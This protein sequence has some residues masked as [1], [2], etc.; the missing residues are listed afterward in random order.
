MVRRAQAPSVSVVVPAKNEARNIAW[1]LQRIPS[2][3]DEVIVVDGLSSDGTL[4]IAKMIAP[5][6]IVIHEMRRGKGAA[7]LA[8]F[9]A[10][11]GD[12][13]VVLDADGSM[14]P[15][16]IDGFVGGLDA[17]F[18]LVKGSRFMRGG[19]STDISRLRLAGN[20]ALAALSNALYGTRFTELCYGFMALRRTM[21][22]RLGLDAT[23]FEIEAQIVSRAVRAGARI[24]EVPSWESPRRNGVSNLNPLRDGW[25]VLLTILRERFGAAPGMSV[26]ERSTPLQPIA[27][28]GPARDLEARV[29][30]RMRGSG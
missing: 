7:V 2:Y 3:V 29:P 15:T 20:S 1:V 25:R 11:R 8:G 13:I 10:A 28:A 18:D 12:Y 27:I 9:E 30:E 4:E 6:V 5:D 21:L 22:P 24:T 16:E 23:G 17:G 14:D 26:A 19:G